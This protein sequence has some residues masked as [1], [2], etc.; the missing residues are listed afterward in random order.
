MSV[1]RTGN[2]PVFLTP[3]FP[4]PPMG[5]YIPFSIISANWEKK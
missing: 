4:S 3:P 1:S 5:R 2:M